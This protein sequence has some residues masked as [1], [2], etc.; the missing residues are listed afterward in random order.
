MKCGVQLF[1]G[2]GRHGRRTG[3]PHI[4]VENNIVSGLDMT[5]S[6]VAHQV[7]GEVL[8]IKTIFA[9]LEKVH[10]HVFAK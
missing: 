2:L 10:L 8:R 1:Y 6:E 5:N 4:H 9:W 7:D 3:Q